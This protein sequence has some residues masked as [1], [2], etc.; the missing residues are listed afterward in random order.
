MNVSL[1]C[2]GQTIAELQR[3]SL[4]DARRL[5]AD[6]R[7][8]VDQRAAVARHPAGQAMADL[9]RRVQQPRRVDAGREAAA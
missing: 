6:A 9:Q 5:E 2:S 4:V 8:G 7:V 3:V 1:K